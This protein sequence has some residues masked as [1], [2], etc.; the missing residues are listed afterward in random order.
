M[1]QLGFA[2]VCSGAGV[3]HP[4]HLTSGKVKAFP[5]IA[6]VLLGT[7]MEPGRVGEMRFLGTAR[8]EQ[9]LPSTP[10]PAASPAFREV[11]FQFA[12]VMLKALFVLC[13]GTAVLNS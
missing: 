6:K 8:P 3:S 5:L 11:L 2:S 10:L 13:L 4:I 9:L 12:G 1:L 7:G